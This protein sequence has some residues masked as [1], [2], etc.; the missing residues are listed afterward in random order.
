MLQVKLTRKTRRLSRR[1][2]TIEDRK[3]GGKPYTV[4]W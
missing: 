2:M 1:E 3:E 4:G